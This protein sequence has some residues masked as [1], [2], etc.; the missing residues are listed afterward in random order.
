MILNSFLLYLVFKVEL[1]LSE[2][3]LKTDSAAITILL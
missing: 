3:V 1:N 2:F